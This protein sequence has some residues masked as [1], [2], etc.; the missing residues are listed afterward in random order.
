MQFNYRHWLWIK[1]CN[2]SSAVA[3]MADRLVTTDMGQKVGTAVPL[4]VGE[5]D[6]HLTQCGLASIPS[7]ILIHPTVWPQ[8][9]NVT[10]RETGQRSGSTA[11]TVSVNG[12]PKTNISYFSYCKT[13]GM[14]PFCN[15]CKS[16]DEFS[17]PYKLVYYGKD[18]PDTSL[19]NI[20]RWTHLSKHKL[21]R[22]WVLALLLTL[23]S[24]LV[25]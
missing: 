6:P 12:R 14:A 20:W 25:P 16:E 2:K 11:W 17:I 10:D 1:F 13:N 3:E 15:L 21:H 9:T 18:K 7:G 19:S 22:I 23:I 8:Y 5:L 4:S 24:L